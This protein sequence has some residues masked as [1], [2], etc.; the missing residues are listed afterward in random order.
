MMGA[1]KMESALKKL[2][3]DGDGSISWLEFEAAV[4]AENSVAVVPSG[5]KPITPVNVVEPAPVKAPAIPLDPKKKALLIAMDYYNA[6]AGWKPI[7]GTVNDVAV[8]S[9]M[10]TNTWGFDPA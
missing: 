4:K 8:F 1:V 5:D 3:A 6:P 10:L 9:E 7:S 2:D